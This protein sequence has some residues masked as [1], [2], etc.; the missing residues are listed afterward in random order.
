ME[1]REIVIERKGKVK[2]LDWP[3]LRAYQ[4][5]L[6]FLIFRGIKARYAQSVLGIGWGVIQPLFT[7]LIFTV[8]FGQ[9]AHISSDGAPYALFSFCAL[10]PWMF[11]AGT[12]NEASTSVAFNAAMITKVYFPRIV[13]PLSTML[14]KLLDLAISLVVLALLL[15]IF[16]FSI[17][18][19]IF[20]VLPLLVLLLVASLGP[21][22]ILAAWSVQYR[23]IRFAMTFI[24]Q[25]LMYTAPVIY[26]LSVVPQ[27]FRLLFAVNPLTGI[28]EGFRASVLNM[29]PMPWVEIGI[30]SLSAVIILLLGLF[31]FSKLERSFADV[32]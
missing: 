7:M 11:F 25:L 14:T 30:G 2:L 26:P 19:S 21:S 24:V 27:K 5:L 32:A 15:A 9:L 31:T 10:V 18:W 4:D 3:E 29:V 23:D 17:G 12:L 16:R 22:L 20:Y 28:I 6:Y 8:V 13:L 1:P